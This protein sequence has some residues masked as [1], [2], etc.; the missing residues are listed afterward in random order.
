[1]FTKAYAKAHTNIALIKYWG[2]RDQ[3]RNLP[4]VG[5]ISM[6]LAD[7]WTETTVEFNPQLNTDRLL[8]NDLQDDQAEIRASQFLDLI[9]QH[10]KFSLHAQINSK[11]NFPTSAGLASSASGFAALALA[12]T[13]A[14]N[15]PMSSAELSA[16]ARQ[17]SGSAPRS[18]F[19]GFVEMLKGERQDGQDSVAH[20]L[21]DEHHWPLNVV[22]AIVTKEAKPISSRAAMRLTTES[23]PYYSEWVRSSER[24][25]EI[26]RQAITNKDF[27]LLAEVAETSCLKMHAAAMTANPPCLYWNAITLN[28]IKETW[29]L[30][31]KGIAAFFTIDAGPQVK[32]FCEP[33]AT[34]CIQERISQIENIYRIQVTGIGPNPIIKKSV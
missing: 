5:S 17:G 12:A 20:Q 30:R 2:K 29:D 14:A 4:A 16:L 23:S 11:N 31:K 22:I 10:A 21:Y 6:T 8:L 1:M 34:K 26:A 19:G 9:R 33:S 13:Q 3:E 28:L 25:L 24:D 32:I 27:S 7:L 15:I 18:L